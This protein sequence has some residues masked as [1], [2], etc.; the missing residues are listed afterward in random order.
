MKP[1]DLSRKEKCKAFHFELPFG[2]IFFSTYV[3]IETMNIVSAHVEIMNM[4]F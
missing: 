2:I 3:N 4:N 1:V